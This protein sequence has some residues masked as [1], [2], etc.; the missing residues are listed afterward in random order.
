LAHQIFLLFGFARL[1]ATNT[2]KYRPYSIQA[3]TFLAFSV[4]CG[5]QIAIMRLNW[6][7]VSYINQCLT[8]FRSIQGKNVNFHGVNM[9][10]LTQGIGLC[11]SQTNSQGQ[12]DPGHPGKLGVI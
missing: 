12:T 11:L 7:L 8:F 1:L 3:C 6:R 5:V 2:V 4:T 10:V 9:S